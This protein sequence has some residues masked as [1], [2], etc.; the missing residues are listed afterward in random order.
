MPAL[1]TLAAHRQY[2]RGSFQRQEGCLPPTTSPSGR[3]SPDGARSLATVIARGTRFRGD[4][5]S[6]DPVEIRG[7]LEGDCQT[8]ARCVV[9]EGARVLGNIEAAA[10]VVAGEVEAGLLKADKVEIRA[11]ASV[12]ATIRARVVAIADGAFFQGEIDRTEPAGGPPLVKDRRR[13]E[14]EEAAED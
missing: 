4:L 12:Q 5:S 11:S 6:T 14:G 13:D 3:R 8:S 2:H 1:A 9:H 7:T 10:L